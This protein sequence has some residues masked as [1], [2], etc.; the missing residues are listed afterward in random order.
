MKRCLIFKGKKRCTEI[1]LF[2]GFKL[3][4]KKFHTCPFFLL[5]LCVLIDTFHMWIA[6][7]ILNV[8]LLYCV[9]YFS[10]EQ[11]LHI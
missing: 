8:S 9:K 7:R 10:T 6:F 11:Y 4:K 1:I 5:E 3:S 2:L